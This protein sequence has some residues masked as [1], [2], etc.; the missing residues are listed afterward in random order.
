MTSK[1]ADKSKEST[2]PPCETTNTSTSQKEL[3]ETP[4]QIDEIKEELKE[5]IKCAIIE[6][7]VNYII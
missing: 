2:Q 5:D 3:K 6:G 1:M 4:I 7:R